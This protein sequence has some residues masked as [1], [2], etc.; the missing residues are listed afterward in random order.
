MTKNWIIAS[1]GNT[2]PKLK[3]PIAIK[4]T[5]DNTQGPELTIPAK[6]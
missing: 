4:A 1:S 6:P 5:I 2:V 3:K